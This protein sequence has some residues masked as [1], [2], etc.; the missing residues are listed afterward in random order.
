MPIFRHNG[1]W[2][3]G[4]NAARQPG[5]KV[6]AVQFTERETMKTVF[7]ILKQVDGVKHLAGVAETIGDAADLLAK[8]EPECPDNFN[9]LGTK[10]EYGVTRHLFNIPFNMEYLIYEVPLNSEVPAELFKKEYGGI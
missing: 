1:T 4:G 10:K 5:D 3:H 9:F 8:W 2:L 6:A 7:L